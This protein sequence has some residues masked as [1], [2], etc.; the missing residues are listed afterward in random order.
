MTYSEWKNLVK[1][2]K[3]TDSVQSK[4]ELKIQAR[5][6]ARDLCISLEKLYNKWNQTF[7]DDDEY[8]IDKGGGFYSL[9]DFNDDESE[10]IYSYYSR[11][12]D[13]YSILIKVPMK[14]LEEENIKK[15]N[16]EL[17]KKYIQELTEKLNYSIK[18]IEV[19]KENCNDFRKKLLELEEEHKLDPYSKE[20]LNDN[21]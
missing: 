18:R 12:G 1:G 14:F 3:E 21:K 16:A 15:K 19:I 9:E 13:G 4:K 17:R 5:K 6:V 8:D 7:V 20:V 2:Y 11:C 10:L